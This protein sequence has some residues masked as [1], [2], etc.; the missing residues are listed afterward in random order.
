[1]QIQRTSRTARDWQCESEASQSLTVERRGVSLRMHQ[2]N[3]C[4]LRVTDG[5]RLHR[6]YVFV[7]RQFSN[8]CGS[9]GARNTTARPFV[10]IVILV[11]FSS[12]LLSWKREKIEK[13]L[14]WYAGEGPSRVIFKRQKFMKKNSSVVLGWEEERSMRR[15]Y[16]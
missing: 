3:F 6:A 10:L 12:M 7:S 13:W 2:Q 8:R 14:P 16:L 4:L 11:I 1:M 5:M 15:T 9:S